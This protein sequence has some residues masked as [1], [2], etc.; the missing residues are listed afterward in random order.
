MK[1]KTLLN[2]HI[3]EL[4]QR[5]MDFSQ[6]TRKLISFMY[7]NEMLVCFGLGRLDLPKLLQLLLLSNAADEKPSVGRHI[8]AAD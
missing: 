4:I 2:K 3:Q 5:R 8:A 1:E 7:V 6:E